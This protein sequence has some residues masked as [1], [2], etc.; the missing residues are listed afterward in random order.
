MKEPKSNNVEEY[1]AKV[2]L[3]KAYRW[4]KGGVA[5]LG[6]VNLVGWSFYLYKN[7]MDD[8]YEKRKAMEI[9]KIQLDENTM[10]RYKALDPKL[11][12]RDM[13]DMEH[14]RMEIEIKR[15]NEQTRINFFGENADH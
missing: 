9:D 11:T 10:E 6:V 1:A 12:E 3:T 2:G 15:N 8:L 4:V 13:R 5:L 14:T 7:G